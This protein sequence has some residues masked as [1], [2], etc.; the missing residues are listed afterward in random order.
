MMIDFSQADLFDSWRIVLYAKIVRLKFCRGK[1]GFSA[2]VLAL[3]STRTW[4][5]FALAPTRPW[6]VFR[7]RNRAAG[8]LNDCAKLGS[9]ALEDILSYRITLA[10][11][12]TKPLAVLKCL[13]EEKDNLKSTYISDKCIS[14]LLF[15]LQTAEG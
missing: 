9:P 5:V 8:F 2:L 7:A 14:Y 4:F 13:K 15:S 1:P 6:F 11:L 12:T 3:A 10:V